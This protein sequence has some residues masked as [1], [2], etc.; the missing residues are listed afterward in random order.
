MPESNATD[1][2]PTNRPGPMEQDDRKR[3][4]LASVRAKYVFPGPIG[5]LLSREFLSLEEFGLRVGVDALTMRAAHAVMS[6][7]L[8]E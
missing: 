6:L 3:L 2:I 5:E 7:P 8:P 4:R 1:T